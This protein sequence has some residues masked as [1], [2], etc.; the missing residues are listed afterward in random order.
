MAQDRP[1]FDFD[2]ALTL[3]AQMSATAK[4]FETK[5]KTRTEVRDAAFD[6]WQGTY[7]DEYDD[8]ATNEDSG[9]ANVIQSLKDDAAAWAAA[10]Q[11]SVTQMNWVLYA[12]AVDSQEKYLE[13]QAA[14]AAEDRNVLEEFGDW[15]SSPFRSDDQ[16][17]A[18]NVPKPGKAIPVP[19]GP[20]F[21]PVDGGF[22][23]KYSRSGEV[24]VI[25]YVTK[26]PTETSPL[27]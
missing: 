8:R 20:L 18:L 4:K 22:F 17:E 6:A 21:H 12:E 19:S 16:G 27:E 9:L 11:E 2:G 1:V 5:G 15:V 23:A 14:K 3:A 7:G 24:I 13:A 10:W 26:V 25:N